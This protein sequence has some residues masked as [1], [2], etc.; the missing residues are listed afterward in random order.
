MGELLVTYLVVVFGLG[1]L[2]RLL[3]LPPLI[4]YLGAGFLLHALGV[5]ELSGLPMLADLGVALMLFAIGLHLDLR[6]LLRV[7]VWLTAGAH[8]LGMTVVGAVFLAILGLVGLASPEPLHKL[9]ELALVLSFS[10][11]IMVLKVLADRDDEQSLYGRICIGVLIMQDVF[12]V[13]LIAVSTGSAPSPWSLGLLVLV[14][15]LVVITRRWHRLGDGD[16]GALFG[17]AMALVP[18]YALFE[19]LGL[20]GGLGSLLMGV[21]LSKH[22]GADKLARTMFTLK[23][24]LLVCFFVEI[25]FEGVPTLRDVI[26][27]LSLLLLL[28]VQ[29]AMYWLLLWWLGLRNRTSVLAS[30]LLANYSEFALILAAVGVQAGWLSTEWLN[31]LVIAVTGGFVLSSLSNPLATTLGS[32]LAMRLPKR[33]PHRLHRDDRPIDLADAEAVVLGMG[34][35]GRM[36]Y[37][38]LRDVHGYRVLGVEHDAALVSTLRSQG[39][40]V[41]EGDATDRDFWLR[42]REDAGVVVV[43]LAMP[44][45]TANLGA[46]G[47][48]RLVGGER[49]GR[50]IAAIAKY[51][52]DV[53]E[54][55]R[56]GLSTV[57]HLYAGAGETLADRAAEVRA[58][59]TRPLPPPDIPPD[60][61]P[62]PPPGSSRGPSPEQKM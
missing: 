10:S 31:A 14:P 58:E 4:G 54:F 13:V 12:A 56:A 48:L 21:I 18:G 59:W 53:D 55:E 1:L 17:L 23:E 36:A 62:E 25:G 52:E 61:S 49:P 6:V 41:V 15:L 50:V 40:R 8:M 46:L 11:T 7:E 24:L 30:L 3:R 47:E 39:F 26:D 32:R 37:L 9:L 29:A 5:A 35:V 19:Y 60:P 22:T 44:S 28:P 38:Q 2:A 16:L 34:R 27:G 51:A 43:V 57:V 45:Q 20:S 33:A 42:V